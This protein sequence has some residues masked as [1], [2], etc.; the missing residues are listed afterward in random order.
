MREVGKESERQQP[1][2]QK[3]DRE[4]ACRLEEVDGP[5]ALEDKGEWTRI[6]S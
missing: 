6:V 2:F 4:S 5:L 3:R 1:P